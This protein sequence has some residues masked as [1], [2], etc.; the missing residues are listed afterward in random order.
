MRA[1][2]DDLEWKYCLR[3]IGMSQAEHRRKGSRKGAL[4]LF[5]SGWM[6]QV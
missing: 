1:G 3:D 2:H 6:G 4:Q 5:W